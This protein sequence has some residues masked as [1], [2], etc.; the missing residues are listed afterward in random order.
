M[1]NIL[2]TGDLMQHDKQLKAES[3]DGFKYEHTFNSIQEFLDSY[4]YIIGNLETT[5]SRTVYSGFPKFKSPVEFAQLLKR[6]GLT[7][8]ITANNHSLDYGKI[9]HLLSQLELSKL[10]INTLGSFDCQR[11]EIFKQC[12]V[13]SAT[14]ISNTHE[15]DYQSNAIVWYNINRFNPVPNS[16]NIA[17]LHGGKEYQSNSTE[18]QRIT[19]YELFDKGFDVVL[20][21]HS[22][23]KGETEIRFNKNGRIQ[24]VCYGLGNFIS[25]QEMLEKQLGQNISFKINNNMIESIS[26]HETETIWENNKN[27]VVLN[28]TQKLI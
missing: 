24:F 26:S 4:D 19:T 14:T 2:F 5:I 9:G 18:Y 28:S 6:S 20:W 3:L 12:V 15:N 11:V 23:V 22:H 13:H 7:T 25:D 17:Y 21:C 8:L 16:I 10:G 27:I 1:H